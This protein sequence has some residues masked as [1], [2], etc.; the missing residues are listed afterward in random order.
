MNFWATWCA[1]CIRELPSINR[2]RKRIN[3]SDFEVVAI[4]LDRKG[5]QKVLEL[6]KK[7]KLD[8]MDLYFDPRGI[9]AQSVGVSVMPTT[10]IYGRKGHEHGRLVGSA[11]WDS[12]EALALLGYYIDIK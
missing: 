3:S 5:E 9:F 7:L 2:L 10:I 11:E 1:P 12:D 6:L 8:S 4:N